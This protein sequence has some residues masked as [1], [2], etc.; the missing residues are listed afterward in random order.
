MTLESTNK[1]STGEAGRAAPTG[2]V[3]PDLKGM[4]AVN[5]FQ[6]RVLTSLDEIERIRPAW[7]AMQWCPE[8]DVDYYSFIVNVRPE[9]VRPLVILVSQG[10]KPLSL[11]AGRVEDGHL[12]IKIGY[13]LLWRAEVRRVVIPYGG[14]MGQTAAEV[15]EIV[16]RRLLQSLRDERAVLLVWPGI[17]KGSDLQRLLNR[18]PN[19]L[20]RDYLARPVRHWRMTLPASLNE[21]HEK[22]SNKKHRNR[23]RRTMRMLEKDFPGAVRF[24]CFSAPNEMNQLFEDVIKVARKT[25]QWGLG[26]GFRDSEEQM[27]RLRLE[28]KNGWL[29]GYVLYVNDDPA[30]FWICTVYQ[31]VVYSDFTGY[32]PQYRKHEI[33]TAS[34][35]QMVGMLCQEKAKQLDFGPGTA[36]YKE[37][38][39]DSSFEEAT[40]CVFAPTIRGVFLNGLRLLTEGP[41]ELVRGGLQR[42]GLEQKLKKGWRFHKTPAQAAK[43]PSQAQA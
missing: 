37:R 22:K 39:G 7:G 18:T 4:S 38:F 32:D 43:E 40:M 14:F 11:L 29:R 8:A 31:N 33:G 21:L 24:T 6:V 27:A 15:S 2:L 25:Y 3:E 9:V 35:L 19:A 41:L 28:A 13:K 5:Q 1:L 17:R 10:D 23:S 26:V 42:L 34:F 36:F 20:C 12:E 30:A 16:V